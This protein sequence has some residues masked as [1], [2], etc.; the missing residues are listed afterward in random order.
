MEV[1]EVEEEDTEEEVET[2]GTSWWRREPC[3]MSD[4]SSATAGCFCR[5]TSDLTLKITL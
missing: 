4:R 5:R 2:A 3:S 1:E